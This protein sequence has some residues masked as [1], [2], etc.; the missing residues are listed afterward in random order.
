M[1]TFG[2]RQRASFERFGALIT[3]AL[4]GSAGWQGWLFAV[5]ALIVARPVAI[6]VS[7]LRSGLGVREQADPLPCYFVALYSGTRCY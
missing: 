4:L 7:F 2:P 3:P 5:P 1:A 6:R